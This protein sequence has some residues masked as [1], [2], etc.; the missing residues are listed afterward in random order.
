MMVV[1][2]VHVSRKGWMVVVSDK[3]DVGGADETQN[4]T[5]N[6]LRHLKIPPVNNNHLF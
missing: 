6:S 2:G 5:R 1:T 4:R 3:D